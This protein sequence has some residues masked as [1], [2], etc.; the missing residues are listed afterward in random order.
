MGNDIKIES[1]SISN[2]KQR[3]FMF[4][5]L[6]GLAIWCIP[7]SHFTRVGGG[8]SQDS[9]SGVAYITIN[10]FVMQLFMFLSGYFSKKVDR[11]RE[12]AFKTFMLPYLVFTLVFY[13]FRYCYFGHANLNFLKPPFAL[14]FLFSTFFYRYYIKD[15]IKIKYLFLISI[16]VYLIT[17]IMDVDTTYLALGRT[18]SY[19]VFFVMGYYCTNERLKSLQRLKIWQSILLLGLLIG[20][21]YV[22]A[23]YVD[24]PVE[25]YLLRT[26]AEAI[27]ITWYMDIIMRFIVLIL[28]ATW[29][30]LLLNIMPNKK[31]YFTYVG[32]NTMP[33]Y[34]FHL[35][36]RY[37]VEDYGLPNSNWIEYN[38]W[39]FG[40]ASVCVV[41]LS[42]PP[43]AK[44][45]DK[46][47][48]K[49]YEGWI[50]IKKKMIIEETV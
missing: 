42:S 24:I 27:G 13:I 23:Y 30:L 20:I 22:I 28:S 14:W 34:I 49:L 18:L 17:G 33:I 2:K 7:I 6:R 10:V 38:L 12:S 37:V 21:S 43:I 15:L 47:F 8:F 3:N 11:A 31:N 29:I 41:V 32:M 36:L 45:Y 39:I 16:G 25:F 46:I 35:F 1:P 5:N 40:L 9:L 48:E 26:N 44:F 50:K 4:D 19:F